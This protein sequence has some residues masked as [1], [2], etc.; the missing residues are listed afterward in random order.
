MSTFAENGLAPFPVDPELIAI[1]LAYRNPR[2]IADLVL[3][4][5]TVSR[6]AF[7]YIRYPKGLFFT[8]PDTRVGRT[9]QPNQVEMSGEEVT[10]HTENF[11]LDD[12]I[13]QDDIDNAPPGKNLVGESTEWLSSLIA[14]DR[15]LRVANMVFSASQYAAANKV[16]LSGTSQ[17]SDPDDSDPIGVINT[18]LDACVM[19]PNVMVIG[20]PAWSVLSRHPKIVSA[21][22]KN[23][24]E[25]GVAR[26]QDVADLFELEEILIGEAFVNNARKG[27]PVSLQRAWGKH[28]SL[29]YRDK[30][31]QPDKGLTFGLTAQWGQRVAGQMPDP[32]VGLRGGTKVRVG[33]SVREIIL[34]NDVGY[35]IENAVA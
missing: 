31:A 21:V 33:E 2:L 25:N 9:G 30:H 24:G 14:L 5:V 32:N 20:R 1:S 22:N 29:I 16:A 34:A 28:L 7:R 10:A 6:Q 15:E 27:Q 18:G 8:L 4:R 26:R 19:R 3:P 12:P 17:F 11:G 13:P 23:A 35:F